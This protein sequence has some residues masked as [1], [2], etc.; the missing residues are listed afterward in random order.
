MSDESNQ[1]NDN[2]EMRGIF[3]EE[4]AEL[5]SDIEADLL[6]LECSPSGR[7]LVD[8]LFRNLHTIKGGAG[9]AGLDSLSK[10]THAVEN[11]LDEVRKGAI[12]LSTDL[13]S[14][15]LQSLDCL[16]GF[17]AEAHGEAPLDTQAVADSHQKIL[18]LLNGGASPV[19]APAVAAPE[20]VAPDKA[21]PKQSFSQ[22]FNTFIIQ[23]FPQPDFFPL[24][25]ELEATVSAL[26]ELGDL[27][28]I[29]HEHSIPPEEKRRSEEHYLWRTFHLVTE[30]DETAVKRVLDHWVN[31]HKVDFIHLNM[32]PE[33]PENQAQ[34][35]SAVDGTN[36]DVLATPGTAAPIPV[37][38]AQPSSPAPST[39]PAPLA[40]PSAHLAPSPIASATAST[41]VAGVDHA[42]QK[43]SSIRVDTSKLD[44]LVNL[45]GELITVEARLDS[46]QHIIEA[47]DPELAEELLGMLDDNSRN[48]RELQDQ[49]M[50]IRMVP[51][52][53]AFDPMQRL[54]RDYCRETGKRI[55]LNIKG[56]DTEV[57]K[58]VFEQISG[59]L[60][61]LIRNSIDH[62]VEP[63]D[64]RVASGKP[65]E[66]QITLSASQQF[67]LIVIEVSDD[68]RGIDVEKV[69][70]SAKAKGIIDPARE[71][72][73][74]E[75]L[76]LIFAPSVST[77]ESVTAVSGRGVGMDVVK[78]DIE[79]LQGAV[80]ITSKKGIGTTISVRIPLTLSIV[81]G[82]LVTV[83][84]NSFVIPLSMVE[85]C[86]EL[87]REIDSNQTSKL[88]EVR[89][90]LISFLRLRELFN[91]PGQA[92]KLE[93]MVVVTSGENRVGLVVDTLLGN[94]QTVIKPL[95]KLHKEVHCFMGATLLGNGQVALILD[96]LHLVSF[97][98]SQEEHLRNRS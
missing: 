69:I 77:A 14:L 86:I 90:N 83:G 66:G 70:A 11:L 12:G 73:E 56:R 89:E 54:V 78:R 63:P 82:L 74:R 20:P 42:T 1:G 24:P 75:G 16:K 45:V 25:S 10:Y 96:V 81:E 62:G 46:F 32:L 19:N 8:R 43:L 59:P 51:I 23:I 41:A 2:D 28:T 7:G 76:E 18:A 97:G 31:Q 13:I 94:H 55:Q 17:M 67:G 50:T 68:G 35:D 91:I 79:A 4:M 47:R 57:D 58:K 27:L 22:S 52:G 6:Q 48:L 49:A 61:H 26:E 84:G 87:S 37:Q 3:L 39:T 60:K 9:M 44:K 85:E 36:H 92:P 29:S 71:L 40:A 98:Q 21:P 34:I 5:V 38:A 93:K 80:E 15:L 88:L 33:A 65:P 53:G 95:S 64:Q 30:A 72:S